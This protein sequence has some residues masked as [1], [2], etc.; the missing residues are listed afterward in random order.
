MGSEID[1]VLITIGTKGSLRFKLEGVEV[2]NGRR[3][4]KI[5]VLDGEGPEKD[6]ILNDQY[7]ITLSEIKKPDSIRLRKLSKKEKKALR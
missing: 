1:D 3:I 5:T 4:V 7:N 2:F 6:L